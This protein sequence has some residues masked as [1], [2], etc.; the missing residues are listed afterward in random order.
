MRRLIPFFLFCAVVVVEGQ[1]ALDPIVR[2]RLEALFPGA[3]HFSQ[4][5]DQ[6][7]D[8]DAES[9]AES[10]DDDEFDDFDDVKVGRKLVKDLKV[11]ELRA[12]AWN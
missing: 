12:E 1:P 11:A 4:M 9:D 10:S 8:S 3:A 5:P 6:E 2:E 7:D